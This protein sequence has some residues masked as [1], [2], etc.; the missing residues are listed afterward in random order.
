MVIPGINEQRKLEISQ[1]LQIQNTSNLGTYLGFPLKPKYSTSDFNFIIH[2][3]HNKLQGWKINLLSFVGRCQLIT[4]TL[5]QIL[6]YYFK[7]FS[8]PK[9]IHCLMDKIYKN[10]LCGH[11]GREK[12]VHLIGW[13]KITKSKKKKECGLGIKTSSLQNACFMSKLRWDLHTNSPK[14]WVTSIRKKY[15]YSTSKMPRINASFIYKSLFKDMD[16]FNSNNSSP[17]KMV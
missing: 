13:D 15:N 12:K 1:T 4:A 17:L 2:K 11:S 6:N 5:N 9:K 7:V 14:P 16:I 10:F 8:L 3:L